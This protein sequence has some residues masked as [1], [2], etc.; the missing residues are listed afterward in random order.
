MVVDFCYDD[1]GQYGIGYPNLAQR[2]LEP[3]RFDSEWPRVVPL[4]LL[5]HM[6]S[7][8][9]NNRAHL[10]GQA[11]VGAWYPVAFAWHDF[12]CDYIGLMAAETLNRLRRREIMV[13]FYYHEGD[14][15]LLIRDHLRQRCMQNHVPPDC[16]LLVSANSAADQIEQCTYFPDHEYFFRWI[17]RR[18]RPEVPLIGLRPYMFTAL[19]RLHK[20]WRA[21]VMA[22]LQIQGLLEGSLWSYNH[23]ITQQSADEEHPLDLGAI[24]DWP[25]TTRKF[26]QNGPYYCDSKDSDLQNDHSQ[27][28]PALYTQSYC[29]V[30]I[31][32]L[33]DAD[34]SGGAFLTEK[35]YKCIKFGQPFVIIGT[36]GSLDQLRRA[37][38]RTFDSVIDPSYDR[39][40]DASAR[41][42][43]IRRVLSDIRQQDPLLFFQ[44]CLD[45]VLHNQD[46]FLNHKSLALDQ[47]LCRMAQIQEQT[48]TP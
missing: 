35:T 16:F 14:N 31:E 22:D 26:L 42:L 19:N 2:N 30:V 41:Y 34:G 33:M 44:R 25:E 4:R 1:L 20:S 45:D 8:G 37:G 15:P 6:K 11:P 27:V 5:M 36:P 9:M 21:H 40:S 48:V 18:Q 23:D 28:N 47:L 38:Y 46:V 10:I 24:K 29:H 43:A 39:I 7:M 32:T 17:N 12:S 3:D 13:L